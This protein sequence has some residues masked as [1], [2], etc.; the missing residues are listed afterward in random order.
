MTRRLALLLAA[1]ALVVAGCGDDGGGSGSALP[2]GS[3]AQGEAV[4]DALFSWMFE[5]DCDAMT[6]K[7]LEKQAFTGDT[8]EER[9]AYL[10]K[11]F[12]KPHYSEGDVKIRALKVTGDKAD[13]TVGSDISNVETTYH[14][15]KDGEQWQVD[16]AD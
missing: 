9:C 5:G 8:R 16:G 7:F 6:D 4:R 14:M 10:E 1:L 13:I 15:L 2:S 12:Q 3:G 11:S